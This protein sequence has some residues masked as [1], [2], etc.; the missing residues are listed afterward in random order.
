MPPRRRPTLT[1]QPPVPLVPIQPAPKTYHLC[2]Q[3]NQGIDRLTDLPMERPR[4]LTVPTYITGNVTVRLCS[5][6]VHSILPAED[7]VLHL[8]WGSNIRV[9]D[10][11]TGSPKNELAI[12]TADSGADPDFLDKTT[13]PA[14]HRSIPS[15]PTT[16]DLEWYAW[17]TNEPLDVT[18]PWHVV[19][20]VQML[21]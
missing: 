9:L 5:L 18:A 14:V 2:V 3:Y 1:A 11:V 20:E 21:D 12:V 13:W 10:L 6:Y 15:G 16:L 4:N 7:Y 17:L 19:L 8:V